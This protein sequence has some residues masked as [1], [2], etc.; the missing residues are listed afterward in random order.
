V[1]SIG[2]RLGYVDDGETANTQL[3]VFDYGDAEMIFEVRGLPSTN[4]YPGGLG[5]KGPG[6]VGNIFYGEK[7]I[8]VCPNYS[9][10]VVLSPDLQVVQKYDS[11]KGDDDGNHFGNFVKAVRS[12]DHKDLNCDIAEGH[13]SAALCHL[14]NI[15]Y[16]LGKEV[17]VGELKEVAGDK[18]ATEALKRMVAHLQENK[19][20][21]EDVAHYGPLL[22][23]DAKKEQFT[24]ELADKANPMLTREYRKGFEI[25]EKV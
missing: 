5:G 12:G 7:G 13:L 16:R 18:D 2:G 14:A 1:V 22:T 23:I 3:C 19:V 24:G 4:P 20:G 17:P 25:G 9:S 6:F 15:S 21:P 11:K 10:G 8:L